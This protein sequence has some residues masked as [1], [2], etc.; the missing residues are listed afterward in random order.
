MLIETPTRA[1]FAARTVARIHVVTPRAEIQS[2]MHGAIHEIVAALKT[3]G[4]A[5][6]G[7]WFAHHHRR[8]TETF[9][10]DVCF[11]VS[12]P[13]SP[14]GRVESADIPK[15]D[16]VR[17]VYRGPYE[18][19]PQAWPEFVHWITENGYKT[20][21]DAFEVYTIGPQQDADP[22]HWQTEMN[23]PLVSGANA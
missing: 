3:Q 11:P 12:T 4:I 23:W 19:L 9:D 7:A 1:E 10:F 21:P 14:A 20:R 13:I 5:P 6:S 18:R 22:Q 16:V 8:P 15:T 17:A 2:A